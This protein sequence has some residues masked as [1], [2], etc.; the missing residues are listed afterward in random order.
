[1]T[2]LTQFSDGTAIV[3]SNTSSAGVFPRDPKVSSVRC[4]GIRDFGLL[5]RFHRARVERARG[6]RAATLDHMK[7]ARTR[8]ENDWTQTFER[9]VGAGYYSID[10]ARELYVPTLKGA[11]L[12]TYRLLPPFKQIQKLR[13]DR[14]AERT[15]R[16]L[17]FGGMEAFRKAQSLPIPACVPSPASVVGAAL[18][19]PT[20]AEGRE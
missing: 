3:T 11:F 19:A 16:E 1:M 17:G 20:S 5:Y 12:M 18:P 13:R 14:L 2:F 10:Q 6:G 9:L 8:M 7:D 15:L 4:P